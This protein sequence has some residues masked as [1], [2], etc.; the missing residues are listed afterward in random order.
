MESTKTIA[1]TFEDGTEFELN[2]VPV[3]ASPD[4]VELEVNRVFPN[5]KIY[6]M[7]ANGQYIHWH[8]DTR[9]D[10]D[11][12]TIGQVAQGVASAAGNAIVNVASNILSG[13]KQEISNEAS[14]IANVYNTQ[15][16]PQAVGQMYQGT[17]DIA[18][19]E[20]AAPT[21]G[22]IVDIADAVVGGAK[23][24]AQL[25]SG[26]ATPLSYKAPA[27]EQNKIGKYLGS[28]EQYQSALKNTGLVS[29]IERPNLGVVAGILPAAITGGT[30]A[31]PAATRAAS[32]IGK[33]AGA[34]AKSASQAMKATGQSIKT[35]YEAAKPVVSAVVAPKN[36]P[37]RIIDVAGHAV[38]SPVPVGASIQAARA[39]RQGAT[40]EET[41]GS[42]GRVLAGQKGATV[43]STLGKLSDKLVKTGKDV[44]DEPVATNLPANI[45]DA[46]AQ[47]KSILPESVSLDDL[48]ETAVA[49][50]AKSLQTQA[51]SSGVELPK[52]VAQRQARSELDSKLATQQNEA[53]LL[54]ESQQ[55]AQRE[56]AAAAA[57]EQRKQ[58]LATD[59]GKKYTQGQQEVNALMNDNPEFSALITGPKLGG[60][61]QQSNYERAIT[62]FDFRK[63]LLDKISAKPE[64]PAK[65]D[66]LEQIRARKP[67]AAGPEIPTTQKNTSNKLSDIREKLQKDQQQLLQEEKLT[68]IKPELSVELPEEAMIPA[69]PVINKPNT[70]AE[71]NIYYNDLR[72]EVDQALKNGDDLTKFKDMLFEIPAQ[73][74]KKSAFDNDTI[75]R[76]L[77]LKM[78][79]TK[80]NKQ[81]I[82]DAIDNPIQARIN[83]LKEQS[84]MALAESKSAARRQT[85]VAN[86]DIKNEIRGYVI[87]K[88]SGRKNIVDVDMLKTYAKDKNIDI[89]F[90]TIP[91]TSD[92]P[93]SE[94]KTT[95]TN[96]MYDQQKKSGSSSK[97]TYN[98]LFGE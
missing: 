41:L 27:Y 81:Y 82:Q 8:N 67:A 56:Q 66:I 80:A 61:S 25:V 78:R 55:A 62:D 10:I 96:W 13:A 74:T 5:K 79:M 30:S 58:W 68:G 83:L 29:D 31:V 4:D 33:A 2:N 84:D 26:P 52:S 23:M 42:V 19:K 36:I 64:I 95:I 39:I 59:E 37:Y 38:G 69:K 20:V 75:N 90:S 97:S 88:R 35:G 86:T 11:Q 71:A 16:L 47:A 85:S 22:G 17:A 49:T 6:N 24:T 44:I 48:H 60:I 63:Q 73:T 9:T 7:D 91:D 15:G 45:D 65:T 46:L 21:L 57:A 14:R 12:P 70:F 1:I 98:I 34:G 3:N 93:F 89:D 18:L 51:K 43:G 28:T 40:A 76:M 54:A 92:M 77:E 94:A 53:R 72:L 87:Q 50:R 32:T